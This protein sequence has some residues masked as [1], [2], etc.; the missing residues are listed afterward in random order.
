MDQKLKTYLLTLARQSI[1]NFLKTDKYLNINKDS[2][3]DKKLLN[4]Q[5]TFVTLT[6]SGKLRGCIGHIEPVN[7]IFQ[8]IIENAVAAAFYDPRFYP[9]A[10]DEFPL[11]QIEISLLSVP[12]ELKYNNS[13]DLVK[14]LIEI[15]PGLIIQKGLNRATFLPQVWEEVLQPESFLSEL[16][17][18]AGLPSDEWK[19]PGLTILTYSADVF[20]E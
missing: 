4:K 20:H 14:T 10:Q 5:G 1:N 11:I 2:L 18:K 12:K 9:L 8:D 16:C 3:P 19:K 17:L 7:S 6:I 13:T 15:K